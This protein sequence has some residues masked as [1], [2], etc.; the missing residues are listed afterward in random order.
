MTGEML[1]RAAED[2]LLQGLWLLS[3]ISPG[4]YARMMGAPYSASVGKHYRHVLDHFTCLLHGLDC[5]RIDYDHRARNAEIENSVDTAYATTLHLIEILRRLP[6]RLL[7]Q[8]CEVAY[9]VGYGEQDAVEIPTSVARELAFS[10]SHAVHHYALIRLLCAA[11]QV[12]LPMEFGV[13]PSTLK[14]AQ[15]QAVR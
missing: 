7:D 5:K 9:T 3:E 11:Q 8:S 12:S 6:A 15:A 1:K 10:I 4:G 14:Y 2:V 13:A